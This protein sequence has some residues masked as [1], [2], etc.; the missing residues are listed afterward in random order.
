MKSKYLIPFSLLL[1][2]FI[3]GCDFFDPFVNKPEMITIT[4][5]ANGG[6]GTMENQSIQSNSSTTL[7]A[8]SFT[9]GGYVF[10]GWSSINVGI[11]EFENE[12]SYAIDSDDVTLY[13][14]W[15]EQRISRFNQTSWEW[16]D[17]D[18]LL[19]V[20]TVGIRNNMD[21]NLL[22]AWTET[23][24]AYNYNSA[25]KTW[26][27]KS[28]LLPEN[29]KFLDFFYYDSLVIVKEDLS[30]WKLNNNLFEPFENESAPLDTVDIVVGSRISTIQND[31]S[32]TYY[33]D[34][35]LGWE[36][37]TDLSFPGNIL[38]YIATVYDGVTFNLM[39]LSDNG[40][41]LCRW[42]MNGV[43]IS[44]QVTVPDSTKSTFYFNNELY[45]FY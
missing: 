1:I 26:E 19:P 6:S 14:V 13:A 15:Y 20:G 22:L 3:S 8:N 37:R 24:E 34:P 5:D 17:S 38:E 11:V 33:I 44:Q 25:E 32:V 42:E 39:R 10:Y 21:G 4:F 41:Y 9:R 43:P 27:K 30:I 12:A 40:I 29:F 45:V 35:D 16:E 7:T 23:G 18:F 2:L 36:K 28:F 31:G